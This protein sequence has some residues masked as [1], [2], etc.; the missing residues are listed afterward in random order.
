MLPALALGLAA[1]ATV[2]VEARPA[3]ALEE[4]ELRLPLIG[5]NLVV[6]LDELSS[7]EDLLAGSSDLAE[8]DRASDGVIGPKVLRL[9][10]HPIQLPPGVAKGL[11]GSVGSPLLREALLATTALVRVDGVSTDLSG[12]KLSEAL[13]LSEQEGS[14]TLLTLLRAMPGKRASI[15]LQRALVVLERLHRQQAP[16]QALLAKGTVVEA[17][18]ELNR[19][20]PFAVQRRE[21]SLPVAHRQN[22]LRSVALLPQ[23]VSPKGLVF[24]SH[25]L[26][27]S[28]VN[29]EGWGGHLAS[30]G[31][32]VLLPEHP[33]S[34][35]A[36][37]AAML[38]GTI[39]PPE[40]EELGLRPLDIRA[41]LAAVDSDRL[42]LGA[43]P[44]GRLVVLGHSWGAITALQLAGLKPSDGRLG[45][46]CGN[47]N[48]PETNVSWVLQCSFL[49]SANQAD[50]AEPRVLGVVAVSPPMRLLFD[51]GA[52]KDMNGRAVVVS[53]SK[54]WVVPFG[55]EAL[56]PFQRQ[57][58][59]R[60]HQLVLAAGGN[61]FNLR[62]GSAAEQAVL[63]GLMLSWVQQVFAAGDAARPA[64]GA[65][66]LLPATGWGDP[67]RP[68][69]EATPQLLPAS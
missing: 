7:A 25:G 9:F 22:P 8:L 11:Q 52:S 41:L 58:E 34:D 39:P 55:P 26:W 46:R 60:G 19:P 44:S 56:T 62:P 40:P 57:P 68:L 51:H 38:S 42:N 69:V 17:D 24:I 47:L 18:P 5:E 4:L 6:R 64:S 14:V 50:V 16:A 21:L 61:H 3:M 30:H 27:D 31:Y 1:S 53:G 37:Q 23:G 35:Q 48:D 65:P 20:G 43:I 10:N 49:R 2:A 13:S 45:R 15:D 29:F 63:R 32:A 54:D 59:S 12:E 36:Q 66:A 33:G 28:P 67:T